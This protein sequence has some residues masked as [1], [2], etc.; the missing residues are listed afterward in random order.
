MSTER[1]FINRRLIGL[2]LQ[3]TL[4]KLSALSRLK[5]FSRAVYRGKTKE[6]YALEIEREMLQI[7]KHVALV[8]KKLD[9]WY[10]AR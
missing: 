6:Y 1:T 7:L 9:E 2:F 3:K 8:Q 10:R 5:A 4:D